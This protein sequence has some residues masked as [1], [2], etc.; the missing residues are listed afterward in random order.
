MSFIR[1]F[2][3]SLLCERLFMFVCPVRAIRFM[4]FVY[5]LDAQEIKICLCMKKN[6][7]NEKKSIAFPKKNVY[8]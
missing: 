8:L 7:K 5:M 2:K 6:A 4:L 3:L 1:I